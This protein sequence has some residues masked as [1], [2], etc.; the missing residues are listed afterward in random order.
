LLKDFFPQMKEDGMA[1][2]SANGS[3]RYSAR[4]NDFMHKAQQEAT[5]PRLVAAGALALG[6]AAYAVLRDP[7]RRERLKGRAQEYM[8]L[9]SAWWNADS[10]QPQQ[11]AVSAVHIPVS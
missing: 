2:K 3:R 11:P 8:D 5:A 1:T 7:G 9:A 10:T 6:A 4:A